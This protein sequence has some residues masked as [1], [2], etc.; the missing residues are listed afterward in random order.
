MTP[1]AL[2]EQTTTDAPAPY[3]A[4]GADRQSRPSRSPGGLHRRAVP[5]GA[6]RRPGR[7]GRLAGLDRRRSSRSSCTRHRPRHHRRLPPL[8]HARLVQGQAAAARS[9]WRSPAR[10]AIQGPVIRWVADHRKHHKFSDHEGDPHSPWRYGETCPALIKGLLLRAHGLAV[11]RR[12]DHRSA[13]RPR[14]AQGPRHRPDLA[15]RSLAGRASRCCCRPLVGGS[16]HLVVAGRASP[17]SSGARLVR[18]ALLHHVTWSINSICHAVGERPFKSPRQVRQRL[19][20][21]H[22]VD[23]RVVAQP[24][25][26]RPDLRPARR[27]ARPDRHLRPDHLGVRE[28][29][30]GRRRALAGHGAARRPSGVAADQPSGDRTSPHLRTRQADRGD[31]DRHDVR[32]PA[33]IRMTGA[34]RREQLIDD[35]PRR[36]SPSAASRAPRSRR[37]RPGP[38][39]PSRSSTSTSAARRASTRSSST[40]RCGSCSTMMRTSLT[41]R[42]T[43]ASCS[44]RRRCALLDYIEQS[45]D[46]FRILVRDSPVGSA[47]GIVRHRSSATSRTQVEHILGA[48]VQARAAS[49]RSSRRLYAQMLVGMVGTDRAVVARR[50]QAEQDEVAAHLVNL[51]WNGLSGPRARPPRCP[52]R[53]RTRRL[54][55]RRARDNEALSSQGENNEAL[56]SQGESEEAATG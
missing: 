16:G 6:G 49:T 43:R 13:V 46:G 5:R 4:L 42:R 38:R 32:R 28:V 50:A 33:S 47:T 53:A 31:A 26:R 44:S 21:G 40:A 45:S 23:G 18:V 25:P 39:S 27:A 1:T 8:L 15:G 2:A 55:P 7:L 56:S 34:E 12:A 20:A 11:R 22:P 48:R 35:R 24:A 10:M 3:G 30:L 14:P 19:V 51:A 41:A 17:R 54:C 52:R 29:R 37:S 36:C 9:R